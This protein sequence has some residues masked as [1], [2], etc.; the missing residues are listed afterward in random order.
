MDKSDI[1]N[2]S[3]LEK[4]LQ[5]ALEADRKYQRENDAKFR[6]LHQNVASY[7][8]FRDIVLASHLKPLDKKDISG[9][10]RKQPWNT[11]AAG[12]QPESPSSEQAQP[13]LSEI[14][15]RSASEFSREWRRLAGSSF[16]KYNL[17]ISLRG[18][19]LQGI[20]STEVAFGLLGEFLL[21]LSQ[22]LKSG[23]EEKVIGV[24]EGLSNTG[25]FSLNLSLLSQSEQKACV[26]LFDKLQVAVGEHHPSK[27]D[28]FVTSLD[29]NKHSGVCAARQTNVNANDSGILIKL[30]GLAEKYGFQN[31]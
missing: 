26:E 30:K 11:I 6:A 10:P 9:S 16:E 20:F 27:E 3:A 14:Q 29:S 28:S 8:E 17:L 5:K 23:D 25:R 22:Y 19:V 13:L 7:E 12:I 31:S 4:E 1:I 18:N 24:L 21:I 2:F 15:P